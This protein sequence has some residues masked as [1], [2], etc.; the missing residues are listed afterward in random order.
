[1]KNITTNNNIKNDFNTSGYYPI[2]IPCE[3]IN[4]LFT[5][6][7]ALSMPVPTPEKPDCI[8]LLTI[9]QCMEIVKGIS[10]YEIYS[11][12]H[13]GNL[14][15]RRAGRKYLVYKSSLLS[16]YSDKII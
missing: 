3:V 4:N 5:N 9:S 13:N 16:Y 8:E 1:M 15:Y 14:H 11:Q 7:T 6:N 2:Y 12:I 10:Y